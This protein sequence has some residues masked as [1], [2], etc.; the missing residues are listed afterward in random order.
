[1]EEAGRSE[2][3]DVIEEEKVKKRAESETCDEGIEMTK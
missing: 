1:M 3:S 2:E